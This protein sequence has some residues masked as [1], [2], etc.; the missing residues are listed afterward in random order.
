MC[1][2]AVNNNCDNVYTHDD[3]DKDKDDDDDD[4]DDYDDVNIMVN[5]VVC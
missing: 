4:D 5:D 1:F 3:D 2:C